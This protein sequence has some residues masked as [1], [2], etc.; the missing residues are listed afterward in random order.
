MLEQQAQQ[1]LGITSKFTDNFIN[2][3]LT[4]KYKDD[5]N[6]DDILLGS[7][8]LTEYALLT[9]RMFDAFNFILNNRIRYIVLPFTDLFYND[10]GNPVGQSNLFNYLNQFQTQFANGQ[11]QNSVSALFILI[12]YQQRHNFYHITENRV[13]VDVEKLE[14]Y[15]QEIELL[16]KNIRNQQERISSLRKDALSLKNDYKVLIDE[17]KHQRAQIAEYLDKDIKDIYVSAVNTKAS[18]EGFSKE[19]ENLTNSNKEAW[20]E[21]RKEKDVLTSKIEALNIRDDTQKSRYNEI[22]KQHDEIMLKLNDLDELMIKRRQELIDLINLQIGVSLNHSFDNRKKTIDKKAFSWL[23]YI[24]IF[25]PLFMAAESYTVYL[26][27]RNVEIT[28]QLFLIILSKHLLKIFPFAFFIIYCISQYNKERNLQE[29]Y[30][31]KSAV[32]LTID[33]FANRIIDPVKKD[34]ILISSIKNVYSS[35]LSK[36]KVS[37]ND[38]TLVQKMVQPLVNAVAKKIGKS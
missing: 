10:S 5:E 7:I 4:E 32:A 2:N 23:V 17:I 26:D 11:Y 25:F 16:N 1:L 19:I 12:D 27:F 13:V 24:W 9:I 22:N 37:K 8:N 38:M 36:D 15:K 29:Q 6:I 34:D 14:F 35:P 33:S 28:G 18:I 31:F 3:S 21:F 20:L 30:A